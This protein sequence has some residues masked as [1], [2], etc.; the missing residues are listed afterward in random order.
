LER[1]SPEEENRY[2]S[3]CIGY[4]YSKRKGIYSMAVVN[5]GKAAVEKSRSHHPAGRLERAGV[6]NSDP[7]S[8]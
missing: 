8:V 5:W 2:R 6:G 3:E 4:D 7:F 1:S